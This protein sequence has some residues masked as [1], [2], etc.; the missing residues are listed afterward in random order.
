M[1]TGRLAALMLF[2]SVA[3]AAAQHLEVRIAPADVVY[4]NDSS[5]RSGIT[6]LMVQTISVINRTAG[7]AELA[8]ITLEVV[9]DGVVILTDR[10][11]PVNYARVWDAYY[12]YFSDPATQRADDT[13][14]LF[15]QALP[16]GVTLSPTLT[17]A[18][19]TAVL[20]RNRLLAVSGY[21]LPDSVRVRAR[22][23]V[24]GDTLDG[25]ASIAVIRYEQANQFIFPLRGRWY[26]SA[27]SS[28]RSHHRIRPAH[29]FALDLIRIGA[30]GRS[31]R[32]EGTT[33]SDYYAFGADV[34]AVA[35]GTVIAVEQEIPETEM[36]LAGESRGAFARRVLG[37]MW[38]RD[39]TGRVAGG[40]YVVIAHPGGEYSVYAHLRYG[41]VRVAVG[42]HVGQGEVIGQV[43][44]SGDGFEPHLH[45][46]VTDTPD[47]NY[48]H[49]LPVLFANVRPVGF[50]STI[51]T[52]PDRLYLA[53]EFVETTDR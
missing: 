3:P 49:G 18:P 35:D 51:D 28:P 12:P 6:D 36:P 33:P 46:A 11:L 39:P 19:G 25:T 37:A 44:I 14:V 40:N 1:S 4:L 26:V 7:R 41:S 30:D 9:K 32:G 5:R 13:I 53:G 27:S 29:E 45:F 48:G 10:L 8:E 23:A 47:V 24:A 22:A 43:G 52:R 50:S 15:S 31:F 42:Q 2:P 34:L 20:V 21:V 17:M 16:S 38:E